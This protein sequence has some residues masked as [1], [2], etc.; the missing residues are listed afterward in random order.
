MLN[1][2][3][4]NTIQESKMMHFSMQPAI[5]E[6]NGKCDPMILVCLITDPETD[7]VISLFSFSK[8]EVGEIFKELKGLNQLIKIFG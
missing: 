5:P 1:I 2:K 6:T 3:K 8:D 7:E 4:I